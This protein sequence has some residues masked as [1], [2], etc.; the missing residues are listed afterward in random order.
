MTKL[1]PEQIK[2][3][4]DTIDLFQSI[5][6]ATPMMFGNKTQRKASQHLY[7]KYGEKVKDFVAFLPE[8]NARVKEFYQVSEPHQLLKHINK[9]FDVKKQYDKEMLAIKRQQEEREKEE[10]EAREKEESE[11]QIPLSEREQARLR[12]REEMFKII[13]E[14]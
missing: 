9:L 7:E 13:R 1:T 4:N 12:R 8:Y 11:K 10:R 3:I 2:N 5:N 6:P 14:A